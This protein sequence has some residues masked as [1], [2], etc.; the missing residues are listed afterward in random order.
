MEHFQLLSDT[1]YEQKYSVLAEYYK[2]KEHVRS[3]A[4]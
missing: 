3:F 2:V 1:S 4:T